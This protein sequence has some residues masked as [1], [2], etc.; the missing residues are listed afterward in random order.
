M[1][2][3]VLLC[4]NCSCSASPLA[5]AARDKT[6]IRGCSQGGRIA[7]RSRPAAFLTIYAVLGSMRT[8]F[9]SAALGSSIF[10]RPSFNIA[11]AFELSTTAGRSTTPEDLLRAP[12]GVDRLT[13]LALFLGFVFAGD[14]QPTW[15]DIDLQFVSAETRDL[16]L[17]R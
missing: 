5:G 9:T 15:F 16:C 4:K 13:L 17:N 10:K 12:L 7:V 1:L 8:A 14:R 6:S 11:L 2:I 3:V